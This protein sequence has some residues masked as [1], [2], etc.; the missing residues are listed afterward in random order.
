MQ[1]IPSESHNPDLR[2]TGHSAQLAYQYN[3]STVVNSEEKRKKK[4]K[5]YIPS[6]ELHCKISHLNN[7]FN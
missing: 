6:S 4:E 1:Y 7:R 2:I 3:P 5:Q